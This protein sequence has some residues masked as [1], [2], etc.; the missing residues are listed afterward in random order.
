VNLTDLRDVLDERSSTDHAE[1]H[2]HLTTVGQG[3][4]LVLVAQSPGALI[5]KINGVVVAE[6]EWWDYDQ[7]VIDGGTDRHW[8][9]DTLPSPGRSA[10][11]EVTGDRMSGNW[12]VAVQ[13]AN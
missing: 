13:A 8:P 5:V 3:T 2:P 1:A 9:A 11:L 4:H 6:R 12:A 7:T 10:V